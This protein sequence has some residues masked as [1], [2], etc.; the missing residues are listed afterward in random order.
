MTELGARTKRRY[1]V[2]LLDLHALCEA[3]YARMLQLFPTYEVSN[4]RQLAI[5]EG[6]IIFDVMER[7]R[8]T[9]T[10]RIRKLGPLSVTYGAV[11]VDL[12]VYHDAKMA[13]VVSFQANRQLA[14]RYTYPNDKMYQRN[15]K[16]QQNRFVAEL[17]A[18]CLA[19]G[20][21]TDSDI[22]GATS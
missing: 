3:N 5:D 10:F 12:R 15:E 13:E 11:V 14:G 18:F 2:D 7:C 17:L 22:F 20:R 16:Q 21:V 4:S 9:T 8:Y 1:T 19:Q 6:Q